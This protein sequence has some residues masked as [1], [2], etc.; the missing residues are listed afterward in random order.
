M[1]DEMIIGHLTDPNIIEKIHSYDVDCTCVGYTFR[2]IQSDD[3]KRVS[4]VNIEFPMTCNGSCAMCCVGAPFK[5][6]EK[7]DYPYDELKE[8]LVT[9]KP[10]LIASQGGEVLV[11]PKS[12][13]ALAEIKKALPGVTLHVI[14]NGSMNTGKVTLCSELFDS[15]TVSIVGFQELTYKAVMGLRLERTKAFVTEMLRRGKTL[16]SLKYLCTPLNVHEIGL[17]LDWAIPLSPSGIQITDADCLT[18]I[19][20]DTPIPYWQQVYKRGRDYM[21]EAFSKHRVTLNAKNISVAIDNGVLSFF[22]LK[23]ED[24]QRAGFQTITQW[25]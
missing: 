11:Q 20:A 4:S 15:M 2:P 5:Q 24:F 21:L 12:I 13:D 17:F 14:T 19:V 10:D 3:E 1:H 25:Y 16:L 18:Y 7:I 6:A 9:L 22:E 8:L 23:I